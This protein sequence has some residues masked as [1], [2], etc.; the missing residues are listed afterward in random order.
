MTLRYCCILH[1]STLL[2]ISLHQRRLRTSDMS[3]LYIHFTLYIFLRGLSSCDMSH[4][5]IYVHSRLLY[6]TCVSFVYLLYPALLYYLRSTLQH[7]SISF[8]IR[9]D[10]VRVRCSIY[11][12]TI[13]YSLL[14]LECHFFI[15]ESQSTI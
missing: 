8:Y 13:I 1:F 7:Y 12:S 11:I 9:G 15:L 14:H 5:Y 10:S 4:L 3:H 6:S 2:Y